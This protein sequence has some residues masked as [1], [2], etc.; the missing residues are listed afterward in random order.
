MA[1]T[2]PSVALQA[3]AA[4]ATARR[5]TRRARVVTRAVI[6]DNKKKIDAPGNGNISATGASLS[7]RGLLSSTFQLNL[8]ALYGIRGARRGCVARD[9]GVFRVCRVGLCVRHGSS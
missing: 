3:A 1:M 9:K 6:S 4:P 2:A 8:S 5:S 7:G